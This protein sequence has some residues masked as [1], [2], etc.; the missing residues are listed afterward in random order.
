MLIHPDDVASVEKSMQRMLY[1]VTAA[2]EINMRKRKQGWSDS[3]SQAKAQKCRSIS[4]HPTGDGLPE[5]TPEKRK[6]D[7]TPNKIFASESQHTQT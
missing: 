3:F 1:Y 6:N 5:Y 4:R 7:V 2:A